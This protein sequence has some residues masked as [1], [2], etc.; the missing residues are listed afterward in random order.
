MRHAMLARELITACGGLEN[1]AAGC[2]L[3]KTRL[4]EFQNSS[5][6]ATMPADVIDCLETMCGRPIYSRAIADAVE[7]EDGSPE[8]LVHECLGA[9]EAAAAL[10]AVLRTTDFAKPM[11]HYH[12]DQ[13]L[14]QILELGGHVARIEVDMDMA[15]RVV[16]RSA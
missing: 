12:R 3:Q 13:L 4:A 1:A 11:S 10:Q 2:R 5:R 14:K 16:G 8:E 15:L 7:A 6:A 9:T